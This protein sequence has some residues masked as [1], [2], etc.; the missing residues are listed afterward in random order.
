MSEKVTEAIRRWMKPELPKRFYR[1]ASVGEAPDGFRLL[2]D[3]RPARTP[4]KNILAVPS[5]PLAEKL[6]EEWGRQVEQIDPATMPLTKLVVTAID[7]V[8]PAPQPVRDELVKYAG[9]DLLCY[10]AGEPDGLVLRQGEAWDPVLVWARERFGARFVLA[11]GVMFVAQ[12]PEWVAA[13]A[14]EVEPFEGLALAALHVTTTLT[15][16]VLLALALAHGQL[17]ADATWAAAHVDEDWNIL[18]WGEDAEASARRARRFVDL[19]VAAE[20]MERTRPR[21]A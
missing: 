14:R 10:R 11:E 9:S 3:G 18:Q 13:I 7:G 17:D 5:R 6:A 16:S 21:A 12:P 8:V 2:L 15:G 19:Q 1:A 4:A 20:V